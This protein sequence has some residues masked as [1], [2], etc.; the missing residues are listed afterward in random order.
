HHD[1]VTSRKFVPLNRLGSGSRRLHIHDSSLSEYAVLGFEYGYATIVK[2][3]LT[4]W[5]AQFGDFANG[6]QIVIDQFLAS[7]EEKWGQRVNLT[8]LLPHG[9]D[10]Q[11]PEHSS[12]RLERFLQLCAQDNMIV[13]N[14]TTPA[15]LFH[16]LRRQVLAPWR[17][18]LVIMTPKGYLRIFE[19]P[20]QDLIEGGYREVIDDGSITDR[21]AVRRV[22]ITTG[23]VHLEVDKVR[24]EHEATTE[25]ALVR[26]EQIYPF[27]TEMVASIL[28]SYPNATDVVW[29]QEEPRN[30]GAWF[31]VQEYLQSIL[32]PSQTLRYAG[33]S[34][35]ASPAT[36]S[37][38]V[39]EQ[40]Q[41]ALL[42][43][44]LGLRP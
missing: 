36:G 6:A 34:A 21:A 43:D 7:A 9:Y 10:G 17:K 16:A 32:A 44:A 13:A 2:D 20:V 3:G 4:L 12:A 26:L 25:T 5:E 42:L 37:A 30:M 27:H 35:A 19:S 11:G 8:L 31:M 22:V 29:C 28:S 15:N 39:H 41:R 14:Y 24:R 18:P 33:R 38:K 40:E 1:I 23:K